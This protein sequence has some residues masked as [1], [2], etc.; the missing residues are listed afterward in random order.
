[1]SASANVRRSK[2]PRAGFSQLVTSSCRALGPTAGGISAGCMG[3]ARHADER[4]GLGLAEGGFE[5]FCFLLGL[6][7]GVTLV[8]VL[9]PASVR[10][11]PPTTPVRR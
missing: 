3:E 6:A 10:L 9:F 4:R 11:L 1:M 7:E 2:R 8:V 5:V